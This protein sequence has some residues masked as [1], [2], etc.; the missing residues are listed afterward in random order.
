MMRE[1][2]EMIDSFAVILGLIGAFL[3]LGSVGGIETNSM[4]LIDG[5][6]LSLGGFGLI[7]TAIFIAN[8]KEG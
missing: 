2:G 5:T 6:Y 4:N 1:T 3:V 8:R 7:A